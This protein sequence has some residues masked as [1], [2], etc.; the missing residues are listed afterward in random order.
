MSKRVAI[1]TS[2][3]DAPGMNACIRAAIIACQKANYTLLGYKHGYNGLLQ[4]EYI[5]LSLDS[6]HNLIQQGGTILHSARCKELKSQEGIKKAANNLMKAEIDTLIVIG[7]DGSFRGAAELEKEWDG[8]ILGIPG[9]I[10]NDISGTDAT[11]GYFTA[12]DTAMSSI[13]KV[14][15][16]ADAF[17]RIFLIEVMGRN[18]GFL[19]LNAALSS[20]A[21]YVVVPEFFDSAE[22][23]IEKLVAQIKA[24]RALKG[25]VSFIVVVAENVWPNGLAGLTDALQ[26]HDISDVRPVTLGHVQ[27]GGS[28]VAQDRLL[29]TTL[30]EFAIS[31]VGSDITNIMVGEVNQRPVTVPLSKTWENTKPL[32]EARVDA[33]RTLMNE[34]Y[35]K[36][37]N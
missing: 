24:Q 20:A 19:A 31:L 36:Q 22:K 2:G 6:T 11:I 26:N 8:Q 12:I 23:E 4:Q 15:D 35:S 33:M 29:A 1:L 28:P 25:P 13:D 30:G 5:P 37:L 17:E 3:G 21:D 34:R 7:G 10:D 32:D 18:A 14:R 27:R 9:T 16:T